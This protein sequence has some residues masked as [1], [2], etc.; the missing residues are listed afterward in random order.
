MKKPLTKSHKMAAVSLITLLTLLGFIELYFALPNLSQFFGKYTVAWWLASGGISFFLGSFLSAILLSM[1]FPR[2]TKKIIEYCIHLR[3]KLKWSKHLLAICLSAIPAI[4]F[5][6][7]S[8]GFTYNNIIFKSILFI[9]FSLL[10]A[11]FMGTEKENLIEPRKILLGLLLTGSFFAIGTQASTITDYPFSIS[12]SE[13]NRMYDYSLYFGRQRY[14]TIEEIPIIRGDPGR[15]MLWGLPFLIP[16]SPIW[17]HR[18]WNVILNTIPYFLLGYLIIRSNKTNSVGK[19]LYILWTYLFLLQAYIYTPL[20][21][22]AC[23]VVL[24]VHPKRIGASMIAVAIAGFYASASRWT[25]MAAPAAWA[26]IIHISA[27]DHKEE[28]TFSQTIKKITPTLFVVIAGLAGG[29]LANNKLFSPKDIA[30]STSM[31]QPLLWYRL[32]PNATYPEGIL[33][34]MLIAVFPLIAVLMWLVIKKIWTINFYQGVI[35]L[36][37]CMGFLAIGLVASVKIGGGN[38][39]HN[40]DMFFVTLV[41][42]TGISIH[43][44]INLDDKKWSQFASFILL[45]VIFLPSWYAVKSAEPFQYPPKDITAE[46]LRVIEKRVTQSAKRG[47]VLFLDQRQLLTF[48]YIEDIPLVAEFEKRYMMDKAMA[49]NKDYFVKFYSDLANKRF[50]MIVTDPI[51]IP[52][53]GSEHTFGDE[54]NAWVKWVAEPLLC[55]YAPTRMLP[56]VG[57]QLL[58]PR[59]GPKNCPD[60]AIP[61]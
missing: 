38:N 6:F 11:F 10:T 61:K 50:S 18:M 7:T 15:Y 29:M 42:L 45:A 28:E 58:T 35:Y 57:V 21:L 36:G 37:A 9:S 13:G 56:D 4:I 46:A 22:S 8:F 12:W 1:L 33:L 23:L 31:S 20:L 41:I 52:I 16:N 43:G 27:F 60:Y 39:L 54:N 53:K 40:L 5:I 24:C 47:E 26:A 44:F 48:G 34:G 51:F 14:T 19:L 59:D 55:Y 30:T 3:V 17:L 25:W 49:E 2:K 32:L